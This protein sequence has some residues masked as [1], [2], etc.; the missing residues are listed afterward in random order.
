M[1]WTRYLILCAIIHTHTHTPHVHICTTHTTHTHM[2]HT[3]PHTYDQT[4]K[5]ANV[6]IIMHWQTHFQR[7]SLKRLPSEQKMHI[8]TV[9][10]AQWCTRTQ[11]S[12]IHAH[13][14][15]HTYTHTQ[16]TKI[17]AQN[18]TTETHGRN[19]QVIHTHR[20]L[21]IHIYKHNQ[22]GQTADTT[23]NYNHWNYKWFLCMDCSRYW[24]ET[25]N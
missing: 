4:N 14:Y 21:H 12:D 19:V 8:Y 13:A 23:E 15:T 1:V 16:H 24:W 3:H 2:H 11:E 9:I 6:P 20:K 18:R 25:V 5:Y 7:H 22:R 17:F 10:L